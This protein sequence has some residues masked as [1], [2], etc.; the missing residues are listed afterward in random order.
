MARIRGRLRE[1]FDGVHVL[2]HGVGE[3]GQVS[4]LCVGL[5]HLADG[6]KSVH[7]GEEASGL[8]PAKEG[9]LFFNAAAELLSS[10]H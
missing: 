5:L 1:L 7:S 4:V 2:L 9:M 10:E 3:T 8:H 6:R